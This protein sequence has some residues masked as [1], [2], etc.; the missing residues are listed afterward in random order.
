MTQ[1]SKELRQPEQVTNSEQKADNISVSQV[2]P[3]P[4]FACI[5]VI[6]K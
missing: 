4:V 2:S 3:S 6:T 5:I 1:S